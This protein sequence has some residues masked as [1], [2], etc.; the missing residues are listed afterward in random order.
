MSRLVL[1]LIGMRFAFTDSTYAQQQATPEFIQKEISKG[2]Q[3]C[4]VLLKKGKELNLD[5]AKLVALQMEHLQNLFSLK[6][7]GKLPVFGPV[8]E[9]VE[10]R[11][12]CIF[13]LEDKA[14]V[15]KLLEADP[16]VKSGAMT[17]EVYRWFS[18]PGY[19]L[20]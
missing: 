7:Q 9:D 14:Q 12:I 17:Y 6:V 16:Y 10:L 3:Y 2:K 18:I 11:G 8:T 5:S 15:V 20:E 4:L 13:N 1:L 19:M